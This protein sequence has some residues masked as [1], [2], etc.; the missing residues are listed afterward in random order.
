[1]SHLNVTH[2]ANTY[3]QIYIQVVFA[4]QWRQALLK[5]ENKEE[6]YKYITCIIRNKGQKLIAI[7]S[8]PDHVHLL[9][10]LNPDLALSDLVSEVK[11][12]STHFINENRWVRGHFTWQEGF[13]A[14]SYSRSSLDTVIRYIQNQDQHHQR[15]SFKEEYVQLLR[16]FEIAF[17]KKYIFDFPDEDRDI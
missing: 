9:L 4:V 7:N 2:M 13:G 6:L 5:P 8:R 1:M 11:K 12:S 14:F 16:K 10:G 17:D 15:Q 3:S